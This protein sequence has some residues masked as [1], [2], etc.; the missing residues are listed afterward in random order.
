MLGELERSDSG[1]RDQV[2]VGDGRGLFIKGMASIPSRSEI[3]GR[4]ARVFPLIEETVSRK[5]C[6]RSTNGSHG[7]AGIQKGA[8]E[9]DGFIF[10]S[11]VP[12]GT[13]REDQHSAIIRRNLVKREVWLDPDS[14]NGCDRFFAQGYCLQA[15][16]ARQD[17]SLRL[18]P[19]LSFFLLPAGRL[20]AG[21]AYFAW[22]H[23]NAFVGQQAKHIGSRM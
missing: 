8:G 18:L 23:Y 20:G 11:Q 12:G 6:R 16:P 19:F 17:T 4:V 9:P 7:M 21:Y 3:F 2:A 22:R 15:V 13:P 14:A 10:L 1:S 5:P